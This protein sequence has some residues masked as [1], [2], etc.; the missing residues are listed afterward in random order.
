MAYIFAILGCIY[1]SIE[2]VREAYYYHVAVAQGFKKN[3]HWLYLFQRTLFSVLL[4]SQT[5]FFI[6]AFFLLSFSF[7]HNGFYYFTR[8]KLDAIIYKKRFI[9]SST[10]STAVMEFNFAERTILLIFGI[11]FLILN[12][13][14]R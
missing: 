3:I 12:I 6:L 1:A 7:L 13:I 10:T 5:N 8:N 11:A 14:Y 4:F 2:G 9:D